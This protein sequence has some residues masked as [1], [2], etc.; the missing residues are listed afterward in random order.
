MLEDHARALSRGGKQ[1][2][3]G[4]HGLS[5]QFVAR[6]QRDRMIDAIAHAVADKG[7]AR[8][9]VADILG[10]AGVSRRTFYEHFDDKES[11]FLAAYETLAEQMLTEVAAGYLSETEWPLRIKASIAGLLSFFAREPAYARAGIVEVLAAGPE[12]LQRRDRALRGLRVGFDPSR[13]EVP[14]HGLPPIVAEATVGGLLELVYRRVL[15]E[16][17]EGLSAMEPEITYLAL[18]PYLGHEQAREIAALH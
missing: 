6:S 15:A 1:L 11:C 17:A 5:P 18:A 13:P 14:D 10:L 7:Y 2:P 3:A 12:A 4:R 16:G 9:S 8:T